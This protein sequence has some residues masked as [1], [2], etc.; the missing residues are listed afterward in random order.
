M[1]SASSSSSATS[2]L[3]RRGK[4]RRNLRAGGADVRNRGN[5]ATPILWRADQSF[6]RGTLPTCRKGFRCMSGFFARNPRLIS[7]P[8]EGERW[9]GDGVSRAVGGGDGGDAAGARRPC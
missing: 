3:G 4:P 7:S 2:P 1:H 8:G 9:H 5:G 6:E